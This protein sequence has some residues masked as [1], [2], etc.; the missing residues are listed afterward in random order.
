MTIFTN[1]KGGIC[2]PNYGY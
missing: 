2:Q 1:K